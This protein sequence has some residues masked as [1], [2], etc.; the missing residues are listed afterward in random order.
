MACKM[1][2]MPK[3]NFLEKKLFFPNDAPFL[4]IICDTKWKGAHW[5]HN[6]LTSWQVHHS[7]AGALRSLSFFPLMELL[8]RPSCWVWEMSLPVP[9][10][11]GLSAPVPDRPPA[12]GLSL[13]PCRGWQCPPWALTPKPSCLNGCRVALSCQAAKHGSAPPDANTLLE[14]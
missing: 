11:P 12:Q 1:I 4:N 10:C 9:I 3:Q 2:F 6:W 13:L 14:C 8:C 7:H 5:H